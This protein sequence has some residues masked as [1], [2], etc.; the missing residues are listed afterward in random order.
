MHQARTLFGDCM[1]SYTRVISVCTHRSAHCTVGKYV[2][3]TWWLEPC[4]PRAFPRFRRQMSRLTPLSSLI[5]KVRGLFSAT[6]LAL[7]TVCVAL[8]APS[9]ASPPSRRAILQ[10]AASSLLFGASPAAFAFDTPDLTAFDDPKAK[11][12]FADKANPSLTKQASASFYA[13]TTGDLVSLKKMVDADW[14]LG[15]ACDT[16]GKTPMHRAVTGCASN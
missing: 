11:A 10:G 14:K 5:T 13:I 7:S 16:A 4:H 1:C 8:R 3:T 12:L 9:S 15:Q 2:S 6:M